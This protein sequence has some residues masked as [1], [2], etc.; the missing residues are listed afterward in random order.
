VAQV[1]DAIA[2]L[3]GQPAKSLPG[4]TPAQMLA[5]AKEPPSDQQAMIRSMVARL[6]ARLKQDG[7][8]PD[9][10]ARLVRSYSVLGEPEQA[11]AAAADARRALA[12]DPDKLTKLESALKGDGPE[13]AP[14]TSAAAPPAAQGTMPQHDV[15]DMVAR[16]AARLKQT[17]S[18][19]EG[20]LM[21]TRS[22][23]T[24][25]QK[26]KAAGAIRDARQA[27]AGDPDK[28]VQFDDSIRRFNLE[29]GL[30]R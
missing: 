28:L 19:P 27:L 8:D 15:A 4:P 16:L 21:L 5:A 6:A 12:A 25:G 30:H 24:L 26:D 13:A 14:A 29:D 9:G 22:Y 23:V 1:R 18:D 10:W 11:R 20:W 7:S 17:G 3:D 2:R